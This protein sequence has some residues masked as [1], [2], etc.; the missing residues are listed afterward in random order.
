MI[1]LGGT[2]T[3]GVPGRL[4]QAK[5]PAAALPEL[6]ARRDVVEV[7]PPVPV[8]IEPADPTAPAAPAEAGAASAS[9]GSVTGEEVAKLQVASWHGAGVTGTGVKIGIVDT[10]DG[11]L[12][13]AGTGGG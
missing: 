4:V 7:R 8:S 13:S 2:V 3:G 6:A 1:A 11:P 5:V 9:A 10:F 12:W